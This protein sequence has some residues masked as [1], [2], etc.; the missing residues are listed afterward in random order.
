MGKIGRSEGVEKS[1]S[2][3]KTKRAKTTDGRQLR[4]VGSVGIVG[5]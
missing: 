1:G 3:L 4:F 5:V 2:V